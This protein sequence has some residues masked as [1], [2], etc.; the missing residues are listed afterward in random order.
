MDYLIMAIYWEIIMKHFYLSVLVAAL[1]LTSF[2]TTLTALELTEEYLEGAWCFTH[3]MSGKE[4][5]DEMRKYVFNK[6]GT[7]SH[8]TSSMSNRMKEG[9]SYQILPNKL[10]LKPEF[11]GDAKVK[12]LSKDQMVLNYFIDLYF[13]RGECK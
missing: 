2:P 10:K 7:Y 6:G 1:T 9:F 11:P 3:T 4:R 8:Q 13:I 12:F 5:S